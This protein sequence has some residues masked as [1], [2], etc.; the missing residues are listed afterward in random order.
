MVTADAN[1]FDVERRF[2]RVVS[3]EMF[4]HARNYEAMLG[5]IARWLEPGGKLFGADVS[6]TSSRFDHNPS[7]ADGSC[8][9]S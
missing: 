3:V 4:E 5:K 9:R 1:V 7:G 8:H 2:D 6:P